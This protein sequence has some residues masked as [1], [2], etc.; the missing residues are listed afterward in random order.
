[1]TKLM[2]WLC[3]CELVSM[4]SQH[5]GYITFV[6]KSGIETELLA[7]GIDDWTYNLDDGTILI[8]VI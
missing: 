8:Q 1:M 4:I 5:D 2:F 6:G 7:M 3:C